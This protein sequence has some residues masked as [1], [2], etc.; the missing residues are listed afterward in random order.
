[1][2]AIKLPPCDVMRRMI[3]EGF[4]EPVVFSKGIEDWEIL[5]WSLD[6]WSEKFG[7][8]LL[9]FRS[10]VRKSTKVC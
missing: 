3:L 4:K 7:D 9:P 1:M 6:T 2:S 5:S 8:R 10:G